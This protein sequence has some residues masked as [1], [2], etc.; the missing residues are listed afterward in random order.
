MNRKRLHRIWKIVHH[1]RPWYFL[2]ACFVS[3]GIGVYALRQNNLTMVRL[4]SDVYAADKD[5]GDVYSALKKLQ[6]YVVAH[7]NTSLTSGNGSIYPPIQLPYTYQRMVASQQ[8]RIAN[9]QN[10]NLQLYTQAEAYCQAKIPIGFSGRYRVPCI[11]QYV[12]SHGFGNELTASSIPPAGLYEFDF[13]SPTW[14]PDLAGWSL[15]ASAV[16]LVLAPIDWVA[17]KWLRKQSK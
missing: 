15:V 1:V 14:S 5:N 13:L 12:T 16:F 4:R 10:T 7:M 3:L 6:S 11:E 2:I 9:L 8:A 17:L